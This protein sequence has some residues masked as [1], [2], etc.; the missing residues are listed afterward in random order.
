MDYG[1]TR[2]STIILGSSHVGG[3]TLYADA[4]DS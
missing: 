3:N 2:V 4:N 1:N